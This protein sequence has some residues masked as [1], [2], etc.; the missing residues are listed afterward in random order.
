ME[1]RIQIYGLPRS[2][3]NFFEWCIVNYFD[4]V[5]YKNIYQ[6]CDV[7]GLRE[8]KRRVAL[9]HSFPNL[10]HSEFCIVVYKEYDEWKNSYKK[11]GKPSRET[12]QKYLDCAN[13]LDKSKCFIY[14]HKYAYNNL[15][16]VLK[17]ISEKTGLTLKD[18]DI[19]PPKY[20][21]NRGGAVVGQIKGKEYNLK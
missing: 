18:V 5:A 20:Y 13:A 10:D 14:E 9:K 16:N 17:E 11:R 21:L 1:N 2:G 12:W 4:N 15:E 8:H 7:P 6:E 3:T 19:V